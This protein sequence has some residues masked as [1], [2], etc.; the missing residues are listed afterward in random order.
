MSNEAEFDGD[1]CAS[2]KM[3]TGLCDALVTSPEIQTRAQALIVKQILAR[4]LG[5]LNSIHGLQSNN[6]IS[7]R[8]GQYKNRINTRNLIN[9][10]CKDE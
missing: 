7:I 9:K 10:H 5:K 8:E 6:R 1:F 4:A 3:F 2:L